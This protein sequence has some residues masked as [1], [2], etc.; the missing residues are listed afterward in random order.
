MH[1]EAVAALL[2]HKNLESVLILSP[3]GRREPGGSVMAVVL[4]TGCSSGFGLEA[5]LAFAERGDV[6]VATMRN[7]AKADALRER[8]GTAGVD[9]DIVQLD[10]NDEASVASAVA[11]VIERHGTVDVLV[12]NAG[13]GSRGA[14]ETMSMESAHR[15]MDTNFWGPIRCIRAVLPAMRAQR[16]GV[17]VNVSSLASRVPGTAY[18]SMYGASKSA[19]NAVSEALATEVEPFGIRVV[20]IEPGFFA[21]AIGDNNLDGDREFEGPYAQDEVWIRSFFDVGVSGG[22]S[23]TIVADAIVDA[24]MDPSTSLHTTV[25]DDAEM[26]LGLLAQVDGFEG[27]MDAVLP[28]VEATVGPRPAPISPEA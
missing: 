3:D 20:S 19:I 12:N 26:Y 5:A 24:A 15:L 9:L 6:T 25:G 1:L 8:A 14:V 16:S 11:G 18:S 13:V 10:V 23:P 17:I 2:G 22:A 7:P 21:T 4:I 28:I 27:W